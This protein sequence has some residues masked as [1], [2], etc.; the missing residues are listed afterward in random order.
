MFVKRRLNNNA[1]IAL[2]SDGSEVI[3]TGSGIGFQVKRGNPVDMSKVEKIFKLDSNDKENKLVQIA[4]NIPIEYL[5]F[6]ER[7]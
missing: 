1:V 7:L 4:T 6:T 2:E 5:T 3:L